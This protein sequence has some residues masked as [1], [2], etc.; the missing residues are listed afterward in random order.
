MS[1]ASITNATTFAERRAETGRPGPWWLVWLSMAFLFGGL[2]AGLLPM[3]AKEP[4]TSTLGIVLVIAGGVELLHS[5]IDRGWASARVACIGQA[6]PHNSRPEA[7]QWRRMFWE[8]ALPRTS[9]WV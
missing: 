7:S 3:L 9:S 5:V 1:T 2:A 6:S 8:H 4:V